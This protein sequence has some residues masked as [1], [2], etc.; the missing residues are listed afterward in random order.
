MGH[1][2]IDWQS[3]KESERVFRID[4]T[5]NRLY[6]ESTLRRI[7]STQNRLYAES[8]IRRIDSTQNWLLAELTLRKMDCAKSTSQNRLY[9]KLT[10]QRGLYAKL[11]LPKIDFETKEA[12]WA[13]CDQNHI[14]TWNSKQN[15]DFVIVEDRLS[16][17]WRL[18][19]LSLKTNLVIVEDRLI[20]CWRPI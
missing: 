10:M 2:G 1:I 18:I 19:L 20:N 3:K 9:S 12:L 4:T 6:A 11:T 5:Q 7:D 14:V 8:T 17:C 16:N 13:Y 15:T